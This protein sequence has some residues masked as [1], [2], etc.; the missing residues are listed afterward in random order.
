[1]GNFDNSGYTELQY[2]SFT[3][4]SL[5]NVVLML[6]LLI[7]ILGDSFESFQKSAQALDF[8]E[9]LDVVI[10]FE[11][12][13]FWKRKSGKRTYLQMCDL[14]QQ[15]DRHMT[16]TGKF[17]SQNNKLDVFKIE[18]MEN[19]DTKSLRLEEKINEKINEKIQTLDKKFLTLEKH[20]MESDNKMQAQ[21][22]R[23]NKKLDS[24]LELLNK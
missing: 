14:Y 4:A 7:S 23:L 1:M 2:L 15:S 19:Y 24:I 20:M 8:K 9:M 6:N 18:I 13:M 22:E 11:S 17:K 10:E 16:E 3:L 5:I 12:L 21:E